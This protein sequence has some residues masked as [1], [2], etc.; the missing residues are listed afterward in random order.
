MPVF[1]LLLV[2]IKHRLIADDTLA[3]TVKFGEQ[4]IDL[5]LAHPKVVAMD[6]EVITE[7]ASAIVHGFWF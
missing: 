7:L 4:F 1:V 2:G 5:S 3:A 6:V